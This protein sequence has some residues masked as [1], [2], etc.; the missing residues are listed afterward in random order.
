MFL[1]KNLALL[2][3]HVSHNQIVTKSISAVL[4]CHTHTH[5]HTQTHTH[6]HTP[7]SGCFSKRC[8]LILKLQNSRVNCSGLRAA[9]AEMKQSF[10]K[11]NVITVLTLG[12]D[13]QS[14]RHSILSPDFFFFLHEQTRLL[15]KKRFEKKI[16][17]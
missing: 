13:T 9:I 12:L 14:L 15:V 6:T 8:N 2:M 4:L 7:D 10:L 5:T 1:K 11:N 17:V 16:R 3:E